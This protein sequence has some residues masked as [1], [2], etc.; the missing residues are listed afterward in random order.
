MKR[1][2][3]Y[4][5]IE[6]K[7]RELYGKVLLAS[8]ATERGWQVI[9]GNIAKVREAVE[10]GAPGLYIEI[11]IP[12]RKAKMLAAYKARGHMTANLCEEALVYYDGLDYCRRKVGPTALRHIDIM[13]SAGARNELHLRQFRP[14]SAGKTVSTG[15]PRF[16]TL[17]P[18]A[19]VVY[20]ADAQS[21]SQRFGQFLLVN[22]NFRMVNHFERRPEEL[23]DKFNAQGT[24]ED[25]EHSEMLRRWFAYKR[26]HMEKLKPVLADIAASRA[27][28]KIVIRPHPSENHEAWREWAN[29]HGIEVVFE[30]SANEW[31]LAASAILHTGCTTG[32]EGLLLD[33]PVASFVP[34]P[35]HEMLNQADEISLQFANAD[36]FL[37]HATAWRALDAH[38]LRSHLEGQRMKLAPLL[39]NVD[40][41]MSVDRI[42]DA[43]ETVD[44]PERP[45]GSTRGGN[46]ISGLLR[47]IRSAFGKSR[48]AYRRQKFPG[49]DGEEIG[50]L[51]ETWSVAGV[52]TKVPQL[53][54]LPDETWHLS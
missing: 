35:G 23:F 8:K 36:E 37:A 34:E 48:S 5:P 4:L 52:L 39:A 15:N 50:S 6:T 27:F 54:R 2:I 53:A 45:T 1:R 43:F 42:L 17:M 29:P 13:L 12:E 44:V 14:D 46:G 9:L 40:P 3:L 25:E 38:G 10:S 24:G 7:A 32:I 20:E 21:I 26:A 31:M 22:T 19:R 51:I 28:D 18:Q 47:G 41:P 49:L 11:S 16:D 33:R 30:G